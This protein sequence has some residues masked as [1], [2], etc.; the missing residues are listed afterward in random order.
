MTRNDCPVC[1]YDK[2]RSKP[3]ETWPPPPG[4]SLTPPYGDLL[5]APSYEVC[6]RCG[7]EFGFDDNPGNG[8]PESFDDYRRNWEA[9]GRPWFVPPTVSPDDSPP[10]A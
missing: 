8:P 10:G 6:D 5:G 1:G 2:L 4:M 9:D 7:Y 3:Y